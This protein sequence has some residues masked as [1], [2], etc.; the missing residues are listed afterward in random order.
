MKRSVISLSGSTKIIHKT[1]VFPK[2][3]EIAMMFYPLTSWVEPLERSHFVTDCE[4]SL[5]LGFPSQK[6]VRKDFS[7]IAYQTILIG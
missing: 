2:K 4:M 5:N 6:L 1:D 3:N 7:E